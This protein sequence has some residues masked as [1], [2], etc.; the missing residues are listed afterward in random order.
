MWR[1]DSP[2]ASVIQCSRRRAE[3]DYCA[4]YF[5]DIARRERE[6]REEE[7]R[8]WIEALTRGWRRPF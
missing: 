4:R 2:Q 1:D 3:L 7:R 6:A 8:R 5:G